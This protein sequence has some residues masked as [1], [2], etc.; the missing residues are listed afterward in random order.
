MTDEHETVYYVAYVDDEGR[1]RVSSIPYA[2][3]KLAEAQ[4]K[5]LQEVGERDV[6]IRYSGP[7]TGSVIEHE[8]TFFTQEE[9]CAQ[10]N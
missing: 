3:R 6:H 2:T 7:P 8:T 4:V 5:F 1:E 10:G 9:D